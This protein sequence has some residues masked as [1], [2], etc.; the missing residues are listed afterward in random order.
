MRPTLSTKVI[1]PLFPFSLFLSFFFFSFH[2]RC[3]PLGLSLCRLIFLLNLCLSYIILYYLSFSFYSMTPPFRLFIFFAFPFFLPLFL[4]LY[5][6]FNF[7]SVFSFILL[8]FL[9][10]Y[11]LSFAYFLLLLFFF[12]PIFLPSLESDAIYAVM[13]TDSSSRW[14]T[15]G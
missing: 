2:S 3:P 9:L 14:S 6:S 10:P 7:S 12:L 11:Q 8:L 1:I 4:H 5:T 15:S 13:A